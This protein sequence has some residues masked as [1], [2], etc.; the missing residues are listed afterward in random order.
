MLGKAEYLNP[1]G[2]VK[3]RAALEIVRAA[4]DGGQ[5]G[6]GK[7][8]LDSTS[9]NTGVA[10]AMIGA[11]LGVDVELVMPENVSAARK[12]IISAYG[13]RIVYS[14]P[15]EGSDG[16]I[17]LA[18]RMRDS[19]SEGRYWYADQYGNP[20]N[21]GAH[22]RTTG[23]EIAEQTSGAVTHFVAALGTS[24]SVMGA[25][26][27]LRRLVP[28]VKIYSVEPDAAF[29][30]LEGMK[31][32]ASSIVPAIYN[33]EVLHGT[34]FVSTDAGWD[35]A[36]FL[37]QNAGI[38]VGYSAGAAVAAALELGQSLKEG[39]IVCLLCDNADRYNEQPS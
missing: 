23:P 13:A 24:G 22:E 2:S 9:G 29:H 27:A 37:A 7:V 12:S 31:H 17:R 10:Y 26:R 16:A 25:G 33:D 5:L 14:D 21:S 38:T 35:M 15:L 4:L 3:D 11:A 32:L 19:D 6:E 1:G 39:V 34:R 18:K 8:L 20:N 28:G 36:E 30:G